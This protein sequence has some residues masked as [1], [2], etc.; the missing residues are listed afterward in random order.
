MAELEDEYGSENIIYFD[1][2][3]FAAHTHRPHGWAPKGHKIYAD[4][5]GRRE[6]KTNLIMAQRG[7][8]WLAPMLFQG[9]CGAQTVTHWVKKCLL[10]EIDKPSVIVMD[11]APVHNK[12]ENREIVEAQ[13][14]N[15]L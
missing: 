9:S 4:V 14:H 13:D 5:H 1:E 8:D 15:L 12:K 11:N 6:R 2:S 7:R 10:I 3:S